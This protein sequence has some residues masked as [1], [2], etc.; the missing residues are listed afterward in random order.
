M[1][2]RRKILYI[3]TKSAW[4]GATKYTYDL[5]SAMP[6]NGFETYIAAGSALPEEK[7]LFTGLQGSNTHCHVIKN[8]QK[9][10]N[11]LKDLFAL[12]EI[13]CLIRQIKPDI[14]HTSSSKAGGLAGFA[15]FILRVLSPETYHLK[16]VFTAHGWAYHENRPKWQREIIKWLSRATA[17]FY[18][19]IITVSEFDRQSAVQNKI[20]RSEKFITVHNGI[21]PDSLAFLPKNEARAAL[22]PSTEEKSFWVGTIGEFTANKGHK[23][24]IEAAKILCPKYPKLHFVI[25]GHRGEEKL[26][27]LRQITKSGLAKC[28]RIIDS[29]PDAAKYLKAV[30]IFVLPSLKEGLPYVLLEAGLAELPSIATDVGGNREIIITGK[31]G[32]LVK[33]ANANELARA[34]ERVLLDENLKNALAQSLRQKILNSYSLQKMIDETLAVYRQ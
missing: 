27:L 14:I 34:I 22:M 31:D 23:F 18:D 5:A 16:T 7:N 2:N 12:W 1:N 8:F 15:A 33:A 29:P 10:I 3:I 13:L 26:N 6:Q 9:S 11:P 30:D 32:I 4:G 20:G 21:D 24:L 17:F 25:I 28:V 19:T